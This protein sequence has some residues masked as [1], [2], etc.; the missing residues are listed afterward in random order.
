MKTA[1]SR[2]D[3]MMEYK[4]ELK[5]RGEVFIAKEA[6]KALKPRGFFKFVEN[7]RLL[8]QAMEKIVNQVERSCPTDDDDGGLTVDEARGP[9]VHATR[10]DEGG[11]VEHFKAP[12]LNL[13]A[14]QVGDEAMRLRR[15][16][17]TY[18]ENAR[19][20]MRDGYL[21]LPPDEG[22]KLRS[23]FK[24]DRFFQGCFIDQ[25]LTDED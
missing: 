25:D 24:S 4:A 2:I 12:M 23:K 9:W 16:G 14:D 15:T 8:Q 11:H 7:A 5:E 6:V 1:T 3:M 19:Q 22:R 17:E 18:Y 20:V 13:T 21:K 10:R